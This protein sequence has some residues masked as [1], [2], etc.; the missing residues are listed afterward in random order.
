MA[1]SNFNKSRFGGSSLGKSSAQLK[2]IFAAP[3]N[4]HLKSRNYE[5]QLVEELQDFKQLS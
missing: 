5:G 4:P 3:P 1:V 2:G